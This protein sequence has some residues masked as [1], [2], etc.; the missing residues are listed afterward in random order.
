MDN[1]IKHRKKLRLSNFGYKGSSFVY[2][3]TICTANKQPYFLNDEIAKTIADE[4]EFRKI[5]KEIKLF[6]YCIMPDHLHVLLSLTEDYQKKLQDWVSAFKRYTAKI[7]SQS[8]GI[9][10]LWQRNFYDHIV[11]KEESLLKIAEYIVN[12]PVRKG[13]VSNWEEYPY[14]KIVD[15]LS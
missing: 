6:C 9:K 4:M 12:N 3:I 14:S 13:M 2:F 15:P 1:K 7:T 11:R 5:N 8:F 10:P